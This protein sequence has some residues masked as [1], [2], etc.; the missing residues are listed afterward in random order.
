MTMSKEKTM[1]LKEKFKE[2]MFLLQVSTNQ[3]MYSWTAVHFYEHCLHLAIDFRVACLL[4][5]AF[6]G[7]LHHLPSHQLQPMD[8]LNYLSNPAQLP[9]IPRKN[10]MTFYEPTCLL[11]TARL[12]ECM[13]DCGRTPFEGGNPINPQSKV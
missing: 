8:Q 5:Y 12:L 7:T 3:R 2:N 4:P 6:L 9:T 13:G 11:R 1:L 10:A